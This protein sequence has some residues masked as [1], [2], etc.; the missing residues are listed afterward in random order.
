MRK[1][2][3]TTYNREDIEN[4]NEVSEAYK[5][6]ISN[7]KTEREATTNIIKIV[8]SKGFKDLNYY[9]DNKITLSRVIK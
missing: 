5:I 6:F 9:I 2:T 4:L 3:W 8:E 1:N 7:S